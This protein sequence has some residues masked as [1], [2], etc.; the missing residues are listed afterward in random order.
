MITIVG[1]TGRLG[2][3][4]SARLLDAGETVRVVA[5]TAPAEPV[6]GAQFRAA[7]V[8]VPST[9]RAALEGS[10]VVIAA[11]HGMDPTKS[12]SPASVDRDG[13]VALIDA[14]RDAGAKVVLVSVVGA[15]P[16]HPMELHRMKWAAEQRLRAG[17]GRWTIVRASAYVEMW[18]DMLGQTARGGKGPLVFGSG[19][20][21]VNFVAV[22]DVAAAVVR[23]ATDTELDGHVVEV[24][25][26]EDLTL[27]EL[28]R[29]VS[30]DGRVRHVPRAALHLMAQLARPFRPSLAR[31]ARAALAMDRAELRFDAGASRAAYPWLACTP[32][33]TGSA[34]V[35]EGGSP[36]GAA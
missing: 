12:G 29:E 34:T 22:D 27:D 3:R 36:Q 2:R 28:A 1:G 15:S 31:A 25:G 14:A 33:R 18:R 35:P 11:A 8:R 32:V 13:N 9:L 16:D 26:P 6:P 23:A 7:D 24:G 20:N 10:D 19:T 30:S 21:P 17:S 5:R 4:V